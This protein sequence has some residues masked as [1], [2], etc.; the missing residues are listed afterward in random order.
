MQFRLTA[1]PALQPRNVIVGQTLRLLIAQA[2]GKS[3][4]RPLLKEALATSAAIVF[5][6]KCSVLHPP[7]GF[8]E[9]N[10]WVALLLRQ[11]AGGRNKDKTQEL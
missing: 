1:A 4:L 11:A 8:R 5:I 7:A 9:V 6:A 10:Q 3:H 2:I